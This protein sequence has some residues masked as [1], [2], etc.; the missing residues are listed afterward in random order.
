MVFD[1]VHTSIWALAGGFGATVFM[2][3]L[4][5]AE[6]KKMPDLPYVVSSTR[7]VLCG[8]KYIITPGGDKARIGATTTILLT[9]INV[10]NTIAANTTLPS[11]AYY[12]AVACVRSTPT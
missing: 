5:T 8:G 7:S 2:Y 1:K 10:G 9:D 11:G 3:S 6:W 4:E 12:H